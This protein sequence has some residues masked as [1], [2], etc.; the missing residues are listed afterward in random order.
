MTPREIDRLIENAAQRPDGPETA[1]LDRITQALAGSLHPVRPLPPT[2]L[3]AASLVAMIA[4][5]AVLGAA[6]AGFSGFVRLTAPQSAAIFLTLSGIACLAAA[7]SAASMTP[8][9]RRIL[10]P[11]ILLVTGILAPLGVFALVFHDYSLGRFVP[12][13][14][15]CLKVGLLDA[16]PA[17]V[18]AAVILRRGYAV[19]RAAAGVAS[20]TLAG[21]AGLTMLELHCP[22]FRAPHVMLWHVAPVP[23]GALVGWLAYSFGWKRKDAELMQ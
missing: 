19:S 15:A 9:A 17:G 16:V 14:M 2:W 18:L 4:A 23:L 20:G 6:G 11:A 7:G 13:G 21:L 10:D 8:G 12:Q 3:L 22:N 5:I 1:A